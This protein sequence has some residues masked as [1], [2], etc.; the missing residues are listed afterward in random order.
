MIARGVF[1]GTKTPTHAETSNPGTP[2]S[3]NVGVSGSAAE[4]FALETPSPV[5]LRL[6]TYCCALATVVNTSGIWPPIASMSAWPP[7]LYGTWIKRRPALWLRSS[8]DR[9]GVEPIPDVPY[10]NALGLAR[11]ALMNSVRFLA[12]TDGCDTRSSAASPSLV[13]GA[14]S[15]TV[16]IGL[17]TMICGLSDT[18]IVPS[19]ADSSVYP[20]GADCAT[21]CAPMVPFAPGRLSRTTCWPTRAPSRSDIARVALS[22][23]PPGGTGTMMRITLDGYSWADAAG[24]ASMG[25]NATSSRQRYFDMRALDGVGPRCDTGMIYGFG[26]L[27]IFTKLRYIARLRHHKTAS[28]LRPRSML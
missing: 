28:P 19:T 26:S 2:L 18:T 9:C 14:K 25:A 4:R 24:A 22:T 7:P 16:S 11:A 6:F 15:R 5:S 20:S 8:P 17:P 10:E 12:G 1:A 23:M 3:M 13:T 21:A 27:P